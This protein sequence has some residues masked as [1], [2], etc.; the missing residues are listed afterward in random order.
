MW[1][2]PSGQRHSPPQALV[3]VDSTGVE[4]GAGGDGGGDGGEVHSVRHMMMVDQQLMP[5]LGSVEAQYVASLV[6]RG[7]SHS[8][9]PTQQPPWSGL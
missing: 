6:G 9:T 4:Q 8:T 7:S 1:V 2:V 5:W 3:V